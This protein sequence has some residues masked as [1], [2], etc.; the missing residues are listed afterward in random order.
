MTTLDE[1]KAAI[2]AVHGGSGRDMTRPLDKASLC[3]T[4]RAHLFAEAASKS[5][6]SSPTRAWWSC[7]RTVPL[8]LLVALFCIA[9][10]AGRCL[11]GGCQATRINKT[12]SRDPMGYV[13]EPA[14]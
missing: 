9:M 14:A 1:L 11:S 3:G 12:R 5:G 2:A 13:T 6:L 8:P 4:T 10:T 7:L